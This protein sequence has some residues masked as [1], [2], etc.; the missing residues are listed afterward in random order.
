MP[1]STNNK[2]Q[3]VDASGDPVALGTGVVT[4]ET[5]RVTLATDDTHWGTVGTAADALGTA[6]GQ[7]R[8]IATQ[9]NST[10]THAASI[11]TNTSN[12]ASL[13]STIDADT[14]SM[15][16]ALQIMDDWDATHDSAVVADGLTVMAEAKSI[17]GS[18]LPNST[19]E[20]DAIRIAA[21]RAGAL[22][23]TLSSLD[24]QKSPVI[25]DDDGQVSTPS[26]INVGGE[27]RS[28][29]T[30]Y[31]DGDATILQ[32]NVNGALKVVGTVDL[33]ST[34]NAVLDAMV[35]DLAAIEALLTTME[36]G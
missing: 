35:V 4:T 33:G 31:G 3:L 24:G 7:L 29:D 16:T 36:E 1:F 12:T 25:D 32:T 27:Y 9:T 5:L 10:V 13:L 22:Y 8:Y 23:S 2:I 34:D 11:A 26:M 17:D 18:A 30:S 14:G 15:L 19:A 21:T 6:H 28:G 20:G